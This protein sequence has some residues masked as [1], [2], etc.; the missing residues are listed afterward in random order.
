MIKP[1]TERLAVAA[2]LA[3]LPV[4]A[5]SAVARKSPTYDE[6]PHLA[7][8]YSIWAGGDHRVADPA[9]LPQWWFAIPLNFMDIKF[10]QRGD[11]VWR[12]PHVE[13]LGSALFYGLGNPPGAMTFAGRAMNVLL[14]IALAWFVWWWSRRLFGAAG[15]L[16]SLTLC[17]F[18]PT[19]LAHG[20]LITADVAAALG[21]LLATWC[22]WRVLQRFTWPRVVASSIAV[23][24]LVLC[25]PSGVLIV[26]IALL[27]LIFR[28]PR[29][30]RIL[31]AVLAHGVIVVLL[32]WGFY[33][34]QFSAF[35]GDGEF[36]ESWEQ[37]LP[38]GAGSSTLI[39]LARD[40]KLLPEAY[41]YSLARFNRTWQ[42]RKAFM[43]GRWTESSW[44]TFFPFAVLVKTALGVL[45]AVAIAL[46]VFA[47]RRTLLRRATPIWI[48][49]A[50]YWLA[51]LMMDV[52]IGH[53]HILPTY[54]AMFVLCG[55]ISRWRPRAAPIII[56]IIL[57]VLVAESLWI[58]PH[59][60][61]NFNLLA[62]GPRTGYKLLVDSS[63][64]W[65]QDLPGLR[66]YLD[67]NAQGKLVY[68]SYFGTATPSTF[69]I[70]YVP[71]P[72]FIL[73]QRP[74]DE[75]RPLREGVYCISATMLQT[76]YLSYTGR[77]CR[78][79]EDAYQN[80]LREVKTAAIT[81]ELAK[82]FHQLRFA[83]LAAMLR[84]RGPDAQIGY[85]ILIY[86]LTEQDVAAAQFGP[87]A[88]LYD[89]AGV[90]P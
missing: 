20:S 44:L 48:M 33:H 40:N 35:D 36:R 50:V 81:R 87:P 66:K 3:L 25:K 54:P 84:Q 42:G 57:T 83:R 34:F 24:A 63:L 38:Q 82:R 22:V 1:R 59:Y 17:V 79:Y 5:L 8:G 32:V 73:H 52:N 6:P 46:T 60:L 71:L 55:A 68:L 51:A 77:W 19:M 58:R 72:G 47:S 53:R 26:P 10:V 85:S 21:L 31:L 56:T 78:A 67:A 13:L 27:L 62:G 29:F 37:I 90:E 69:G 12:R 74:S 30:S 9:H 61:A 23:A 65:G 2:L 15:G 64:D 4:M 70:V 75:V 86:N 45:A 80:A 89:D 7:A 49:L 88:E 18:S 14:A 41:L 43:N 16:I 76:T 28:R 39:A 11:D